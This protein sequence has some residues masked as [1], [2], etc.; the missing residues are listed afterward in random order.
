M[1]D[2]PAWESKMGFFSFFIWR[3]V[4]EIDRRA[5]LGINPRQEEL[6]EKATCGLKFSH[7]ETNQQ[8]GKHPNYSSDAFLFGDPYGIS[9]AE[10]AWHQ[11]A[12]K[13]M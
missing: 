13:K 6:N 12:P 2:D 8:K 3:P 5:K 1:N 10:Q 7:T 9:T 4:R 11:S